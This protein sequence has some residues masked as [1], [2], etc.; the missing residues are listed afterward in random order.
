VY[1]RRCPVQCPRHSPMTTAPAM[2]RHLQIF[3]FQPVLLS[4]LRQQSAADLVTIMECNSVVRPTCAFEPSM[5]TVLPGHFPAHAQQGSQQLPGLH[6]GPEAHAIENTSA[7]GPGT[8]SPWSIQSA[9]IRS[10]SERTAVIAASRELPYSITPGIGSMSAH[11]RPS[12]SRPTV[13]GIDSTVS[14]CIGAHHAQ[15]SAWL[16]PSPLAE[17]APTQENGRTQPS[18]CSIG[19]LLFL[20]RSVRKLSTAPEEMAGNGQHLPCSRHR[21]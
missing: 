14:E 4:D 1:C 18:L 11:Q 3:R 12:S 15:A 7:N 5:R 2:P 6:R 21:Q 10:A 20:S 16:L 8:S 19:R 17:C 13:I 9:T